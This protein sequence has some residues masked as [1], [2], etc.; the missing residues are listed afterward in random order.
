MLTAVLG[1][2][3]R[4][5][6]IVNVLSNNPQLSEADF[7]Q[8][9]QALNEIYQTLTTNLENARTIATPALSNV[10]AGS[11]LHTLIA[12]WG[13]TELYLLTDDNI[14]GQWIGKL[15]T[16]LSAVSTRL[17]RL[18][19]KSLGSILTFQEK[20]ARQWT[21]EPAQQPAPSLPEQIA[22]PSRT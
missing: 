6:A 14:T 1:E 13:D 7:H 4:L 17:K 21:A 5:Q 9:R 10:P 3:S 2:E 19:F 15:A 12:D 20:L 8:L 16:R 18:H 11:S 22:E